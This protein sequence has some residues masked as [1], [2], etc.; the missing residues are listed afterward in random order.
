M[1]YAQNFTKIYFNKKKNVK[2]KQQKKNSCIRH[3][4]VM[5]VKVK[6]KKECTALNGICWEFWIS[7]FLFFLLF[8]RVFFFNINFEKYIRM[9]WGD[10]ETAELWN[11]QAKFMKIE[12]NLNIIWNSCHWRKFFIFIWKIILSYVLFL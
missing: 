4:A 3:V 8:G 9:S 6:E 2:K 11:C 7:W 10:A 5:Y 12:R 1:L